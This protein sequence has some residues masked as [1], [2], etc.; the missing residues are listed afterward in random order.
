[1]NGY[2]TLEKGEIIEAGDEY[3]AC[4]N[5]WKDDANWKPAPAHMV[6]KPASDPKYPA[7]TIYRRRLHPA[8]DPNHCHPHDCGYT[9]TGH[10]HN[11]NCE[12]REHD[13]TG[14]RYPERSDTTGGETDSP[15]GKLRHSPSERKA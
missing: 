13:N 7:H 12:W 1:M 15:N 4:S 10:I 11:C 5:A 2:R 9:V 14:M 3:D 8:D 6:G